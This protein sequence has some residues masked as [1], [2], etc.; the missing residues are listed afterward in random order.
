MQAALKVIEK[1]AIGSTK[2]W[3]YVLREIY[4]LMSLDHP[5]CVKLHIAVQTQQKVYICM[6]LA[7]VKP[8]SLAFPTETCAFC[9]AGRPRFGG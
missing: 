4:T 2:M 6:D 5:C 9:R 1:R 8:M 3:D 7:K